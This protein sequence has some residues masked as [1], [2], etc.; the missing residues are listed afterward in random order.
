[1]LAMEQQVMVQL[2][3]VQERMVRLVQARLLI[4]VLQIINMHLLAVE[5]A[6]MVEEV[7]EQTEVIQL[8]IVLILVAALVMYILHL[9]HRIIQLVTN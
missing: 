5:V 9:L 6:G 3:L 4:Q 8:I 1:M 2:L 7:L